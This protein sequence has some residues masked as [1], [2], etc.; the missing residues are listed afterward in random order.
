MGR[1]QA[2]YLSE[3]SEMAFSP[4]FAIDLDR[5]SEIL[6]GVDYSSTEY[7][8]PIWSFFWDDSSED[9]V[10]V[11]GFI[12]VLERLE[13]STTHAV[14]MLDLPYI[15]TEEEPEPEAADIGG[16]GWSY[17]NND[18]TF[19]LNLD[20]FEYVESIDGIFRYT[21]VPYDNL[22][23]MGWPTEPIEFLSVWSDGDSYGT[24]P[25][26]NLY[27]N[28]MGELQ[29]IGVVNNNTYATI[30]FDIFGMDDEYEM[31]FWLNG[32]ELADGV[33]YMLLDSP[34]GSDKYYLVLLESVRDM[35]QGEDDGTLEIYAYVEDG[36]VVQFTI[37]AFDY[38][39]LNQRTGFGFGRFR[40]ALND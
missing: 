12:F 18:G 34:Y 32:Y 9:T 1:V 16:E 6:G 19:Q 39:Y 8:H 29:D 23:N 4:S 3:E 17:D 26:I 15:D 40:P 11:G 21:L 14:A 38:I 31:E 20:P 28:W 22:G 36:I 37:D 35:I 33:D 25:F 7:E 5:P 27:D 30:S 10:G 2:I 24:F 13:G